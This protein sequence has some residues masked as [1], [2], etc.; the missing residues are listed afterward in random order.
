MTS[1]VSNRKPFPQ[2]IADFSAD[3]RTTFYEEDNKWVLEDFDG[4]E[5]EFSVKLDK[6]TPLVG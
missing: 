2:S 4:T 5:W 3:D 6:W 1:S